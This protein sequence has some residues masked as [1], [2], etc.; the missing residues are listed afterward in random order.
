MRYTKPMPVKAAKFEKAAKAEVLTGID[1]LERGGFSFL[2]GC[3]VG[4]VTNHTGLTC[5][6]KPTI[7]VLH[8]APGVT[9]TALFGPEHGMRG[10]HDESVADGTDAGTALPV[11]SLFGARTVPTPEQMAGLDTLVFDI[12]DI[13][14]R[15]YTYLSTLGNILDAASTHNLR[16]VVLDRPN[17]LTGTHTE[18]PMTDPDKLSFVA[19]HPIPIR[20]GLTLG[21]MARLIHAEKKLSC[22]LEIVACEHWCRDDWYDATGL[23]W[24]NPSPNMRRLSA[25]ALYPG[26][27]LLEFTNVSVGRGT[28]TPFEIFGAPYIAPRSF[29]AALNEENLPGVRFIPTAFTPSSSVFAGEVCGGVQTLVTDREAL[30]AVQVGLTLATTLRRLSPEQWQPEKLATLLCHSHTLTRLREGD[31]ASIIAAGWQEDL[32]AWTERSQPHLLY[33]TRSG[34]H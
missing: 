15:F 16:V 11:Y 33:G 7:D 28:D 1:V 21:E 6:G 9:L 20:H 13:G 8:Q 17:P 23:L 29:A 27:G 14:C 10:D 19:C 2:S 32:S 12:Q 22:T 30:N 3:R 25:A 34:S 24:A 18:G 31:S 26:V 4:L 5:E